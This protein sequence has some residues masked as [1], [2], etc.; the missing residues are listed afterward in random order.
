[1]DEPKPS[2]VDLCCLC[3]SELEI[4]SHVGDLDL[5]DRVLAAVLVLPSALDK[6]ADHE[7]PHPFFM[8]GLCS[9][10][11]IAMPCSGRPVVDV[12]SLAVVL[13]AVADGATS[14]APFCCARGLRLVSQDGDS[15]EV[16][17]RRSRSEHPWAR[18]THG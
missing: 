9:R 15:D 10:R 18:R 12:L 11:P 4:R 16:N 13:G 3:G 1:M 2:A 6:L 17:R 14:F 7:D 5:D 8:C